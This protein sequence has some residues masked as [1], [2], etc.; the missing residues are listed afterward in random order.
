MGFSIFTKKYLCKGSAW[1][2]DSLMQFL[3][4][5]LVPRSLTGTFPVVN[6]C[7]HCCLSC[8]DGKAK[9]SRI[10]TMFFFYIA[11]SEKPMFTIKDCPKAITG[12]LLAFVHLLIKS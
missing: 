9:T 4:S 12:R 8:E 3:A 2:P 11:S 5:N 7:N 1:G 6:E 10:I